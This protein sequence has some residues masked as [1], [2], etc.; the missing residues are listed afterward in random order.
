[1]TKTFAAQAASFAAAALFTVATFSA[2]GAI[3]GHAYR[4]ASAS[5]LQAQPAAVA[6]T[7]YVTVVGHRTARA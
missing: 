6:V 5:Q 2:T 4:T 1:M 7:Q 3:A